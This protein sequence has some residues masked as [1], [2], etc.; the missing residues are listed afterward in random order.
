LLCQPEFVST[1]C[2]H[3]IV[4]ASMTAMKIYHH[5]GSYI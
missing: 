4:I 2:E 3:S 5:K 1:P